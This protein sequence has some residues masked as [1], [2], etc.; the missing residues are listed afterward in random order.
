MLNS[1]FNFGNK[2]KRES[3]VHLVAPL[4]KGFSQIGSPNRTR[5]YAANM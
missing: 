3:T 2:I 4:I 5:D 1:L